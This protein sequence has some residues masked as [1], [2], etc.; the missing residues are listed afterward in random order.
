MSRISELE[1]RLDTLTIEVLLP[2][3]MS[4]TVETE[5]V[6]RMYA[7]VSELAAELGDSELVPRL[8][9]GSFGSYSLRC[10]L[11]LITRDRQMTFS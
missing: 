8:L 3:R 10:S 5:A 4:K 1:G 6:N 11:R 2:L 9:V 7:L